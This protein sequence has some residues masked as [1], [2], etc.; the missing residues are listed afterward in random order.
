MQHPVSTQRIGVVLDPLGGG[1][2]GA[3]GVDAEQAGQ[4]AVVHRDCLGDLQEPDGL[5]AVQ[6]LGA[7]LVAV[8][9][10]RSRLLRWVGADKAVD[11]RGAEVAAHGVHHRVD[12]GVHQPAVA[13][14]GDV[15]LDV[16]S[17][18]PGQGVEPVALAPSEPLAQLER[19]EGVGAPGVSGQVGDRRQLRPRHRRWLER[20]RSRRSG[21]GVTSRGDRLPDQTP[22]ARKRGWASR[23]CLLSGA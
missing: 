22:L 16:G 17:L 1:F 21:H 4:R 6:A 19:V 15:E 20:Q 3:E 2:G 11:A 12:R 10:R 5:E 18:N 7:G 13:E 14:A 9:L 23:A 8:D